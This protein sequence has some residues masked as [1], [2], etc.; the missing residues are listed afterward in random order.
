MLI[1]K[2]APRCGMPNAAKNTVSSYILYTAPPERR[3]YSAF[4]FLDRA[5]EEPRIDAQNGFLN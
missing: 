4:R 3:I 1:A 2:P 5:P